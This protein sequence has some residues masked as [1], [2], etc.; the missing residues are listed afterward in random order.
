MDGHERVDVVEHRGVFLG[1][2][3]E[4]CGL[5]GSNSTASYAKTRHLQ[6]TICSAVRD[7]F[8]HSVKTFESINV[9]LKKQ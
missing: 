9:G 5:K 7:E 6:L 1:A 4:N 2:M 3:G 8:C